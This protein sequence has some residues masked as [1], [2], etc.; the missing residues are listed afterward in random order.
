MLALPAQA[1]MLAS[2]LYHWLRYDSLAALIG[3]G[4]GIL[5]YLVLLSV[6]QGAKRL[7]GRDAPHGSW[8]WVARRMVDRTRSYFLALGSMEAVSVIAGAPQAWLAVVGFLFTVAAAIQGAW[9]VRELALAMIERRARADHDADSALGVLNVLISVAVWA[10]T[11]VL[12]LDNLGV[13]VTALV[14]GLGIGGIAIG[15]AAQG[16]FSDLFAAMAILLDRPFRRGDTISFGAP[17]NFTTGTV[18]SIGLKTTRLRAPAGEEVVV[19]N[20]K[21]L[22]DQIRNVARIEARTV[23]MTFLLDLDSAP[24]RLARLPGVLQAAVERCD[25]AAFVRAAV[26]NVTAAAFE[27]ELAFTL[28]DPDFAAMQRTRQA[29][30]LAV[31]DGLAAEG[32]RLAHP[33]V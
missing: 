23:T 20:T 5:L 21:L 28:A 13:D 16:I 2:Q 32:L 22:S 12:L 19:S 26:H 14:A 27:S 3:I 10:L 25:G 6:R 33:R 11:L 4:L 8:R 9:W 18:E 24:D 15:L 31:L 7:L 29:I 17:N 1:R 30:L